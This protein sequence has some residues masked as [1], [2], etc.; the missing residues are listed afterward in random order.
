MT[1]DDDLHYPTEL[2]DDA[3][4]ASRLAAGWRATADQTFG[5]L[6]AQ[7]DL[8]Q[9]TA[10]LA[11]DLAR[12]LREA[13]PGL[14]A[15]LGAWESRDALVAEVT[16]A[17]PGPAGDPAPAVATAFAL[18]YAEVLAEVA[19]AQ[20]LERLSAEGA[21]SEWVILEEAGS[22]EGD[23]FLP[24]RR[25]EA[26]RQTGRALLATTSPDDTLT[27]CVHEVASGR[28]DLA[29]GRLDW[30]ESSATGGSPLPDAAAREAA[31]A[32]LKRDP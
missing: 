28:I 14:T 7:P 15:L 3:A 31:L 26:H 4:R 16:A 19:A 5:A 10:L 21:D 24:Y 8:Y 25:V 6:A 17:R 22:P 23:P 27:G 30:D 13:G 2:D 9:R 20:R 32:A 18:R 11:G 12:R 29:T 1:S